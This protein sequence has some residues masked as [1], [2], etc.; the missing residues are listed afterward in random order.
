MSVLRKEYDLGSHV[1][2]VWYESSNVVY[3]KF[4]ED[5]DENTGE[6]YVVFKGGKQY[7]YKSVSYQDYL[8]FKGGGLDGSSG[9]ALNEY[10]IKKYK[11]EK[12]E[13]VNIDELLNRLNAP[14]DEDVTYYIHGDGEFDENVV[15]MFYGPTVEYCQQLSSDIRFVTTLYDRYGFE[16]VKY[17]VETGMDPE[18]F[19]ILMRKFDEITITLYEELEDCKKVYID[20]KEWNDEFVAQ[21]LRKMSK[22]DIAFVSPEKLEEIRKLSPSA[23]SIL[24]RRFE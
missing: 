18:R 15:S 23:Y 7:L 4:V 10:I 11:G 22:D 2:E 14:K 5:K 9:R 13:D 6:L 3:S 17:C 24:M 16:T 12:M 1:D 19:T 20:D 21:Q 8:Y